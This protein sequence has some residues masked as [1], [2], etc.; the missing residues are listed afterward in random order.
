MIL[1]DI[2]K[3]IESEYNIINNTP[4]EV[5]GGDY[6]AEQLEILL[7]DDVPFDVCEC[8][9]CNCGHEKTFEFYAP[10]INEKDLKNLKNLN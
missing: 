9:C 5:C 1:T 7:I 4:C 3:Y 8:S 6:E 2:M 10:F